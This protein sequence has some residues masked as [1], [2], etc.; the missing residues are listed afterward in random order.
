[1]ILEKK[2]QNI[3]ETVVFVFHHGIWQSEFSGYTFY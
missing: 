2:T 1:M 3:G